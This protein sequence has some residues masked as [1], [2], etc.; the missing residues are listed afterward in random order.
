VASAGSLHVHRH[1]LALVTRSLHSTLSRAPEKATDINLR[2]HNGGAKALERGSYLP[3]TT[4]NSSLCGVHKHRQSMQHRGSWTTTVHWNI[5]LFDAPIKAQLLTLL[6]I[7]CLWPCKLRLTD[8]PPGCYT[9][10]KGIVPRF[11][12]RI[13]YSSFARVTGLVQTLVLG[14]ERGWP[15]WPG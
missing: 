7:Q 4:A 11:S 6:W 1:T 13:L 15:K 2:R 3:A 5:D 8:P 10:P 14:P 12:G 9:G